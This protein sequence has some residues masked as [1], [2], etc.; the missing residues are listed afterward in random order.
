MCKMLLKVNCFA[1]DEGK[2]LICRVFKQALNYFAFDEGK[3]LICRVFK[4]AEGIV[5]CVYVEFC[6]I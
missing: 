5:F 2:T 1:F 6:I 3:T 4:E